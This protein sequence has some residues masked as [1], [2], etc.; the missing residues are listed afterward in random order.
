MIRTSSL[1]SDLAQWDTLYVAGRM[2]K[3]VATLAADER[4]AAASDGNLR[5]AL[6][7]ALLLLPVRS[8]LLAQT[9][10][11]HADVLSVA[12]FG[13][14]AAHHPLRSLLHGRCAHGHCR[15]CI[16]GE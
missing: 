5:A 6:A 15:G 14:A 3:P 10:R 9:A 1:L 13:A 11:S 2:R 7:C 4:V 12:F 16:Q 8:W